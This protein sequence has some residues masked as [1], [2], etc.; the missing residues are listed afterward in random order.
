M[1]SLY[2]FLAIALLQHWVENDKNPW[3]AIA[4]GFFAAS[5]GW[6]KNEGL[7]LFA[8][9]SLVFVLSNRFSLRHTGAFACGTALPLAIILV[10]KLCFTPQNDF[11]SQL[12]VQNITANLLDISRYIHVLKYFTINIVLP[13]YPHIIILLIASIALGTR[14]LTVN[15]LVIGTIIM[16]YTTVYVITQSGLD[17]NL[18]TS[19]DRLFNQVYPSVLFVLVN[20][21]RNSRRFNNALAFVTKSRFIN[22]NG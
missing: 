19:G 1:V 16:L 7:L 12:N 11:I 17:W 5:G 9:I 21:F 22:T 3:V 8:I 10:Y 13:Y 6:V 18:D 2:L 4:L 14:K 20:S 15:T